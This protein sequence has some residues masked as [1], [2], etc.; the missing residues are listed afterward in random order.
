MDTWPVKIEKSGNEWKVFPAE[1]GGGKVYPNYNNGQP[2]EIK[3]GDEIVF[4]VPGN[5]SA[6]AADRTHVTVIISPTIF[7]G[8]GHVRKI[9][10][11]SDQTGYNGKLT[12]KKKAKGNTFL[13][14]AF[15]VDVDE[16]ATGSY[17]RIIIRP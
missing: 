15:C 16:V 8:S 7:S 13:Y 10:I 17:P 12:V 1:L 3:V 14:A 4:N 9:D 11:K 6:L 5:A 2:V